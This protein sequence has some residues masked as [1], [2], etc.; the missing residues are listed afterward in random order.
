MSKKL[1]R[2][3]KLVSRKFIYYL[4]PSMLMIFA[5]QFSSLLDGILIGN[6]ISGEALAATSLVMPVLY[7]IQAPGFALGVGGS[8]VVANKLGK[9]DIEGAK[10]AFSIAI[11]ISVGLSLIFAGVS[12]FVSSPL[13]KLF[14]EASYEY[15][16]PYIYMYLLTDPIL[17]IA[18]LLGSFMAVDN[19]PK[20]SSIFFIIANVA[21]VGFEFLFIKTFP[22]PM[23]GAALSTG[24]GFFVALAV[25]PF[26]LK[27]KKR[28]LKFSF[29]VKNAGIFSI[30]K[31]SST[32]GV[33][34]VLTATQMLIV[35]IFLGKLIT[36]PVDLLAF[37]LISNVVFVFDLFCGGILNVIPNICGIFYGEK[38]YYS[39]RS[40]TRKIYWINFIV[41]C[42]ITAFIAIA[43]QV[44]SYIFGYTD[45][46]NMDY[47]GLLIR[48]YLIS[49]L[50]YE[51]NKFNMNYYPSVDKTIPSLVTV[52][53]REAIIVLPLTLVLLHTNGIM[54]YCIACAVTEVATVLITYGFVLIYNK[55]KN[56]RGIFMFERGDVESFDV[57]LDNN[58]DNASQVSEQ[59]TSFAKEHGIQERESQIVGLAAEEIVANIITYGYRHNHKNYIDVSLKKTDKALILRIRDDGMP[60]DPTKYE[61][62]N[63]D[64]YSTSG[65]QLISKLTDKMTYMRVL[66]LNNTIFEINIGGQH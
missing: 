46:S 53:L 49:F 35:N 41:T 23:Y 42:A 34:M 47:V 52:F 51:I 56:T 62:D 66:N 60:F 40:V 17:T 44:Y 18:L 25:V 30:V 19:N 4:I 21:K 55:R 32:S 61:F 26:Y 50:P 12:F 33:N 64:N 8:I 27:S 39:L 6:L 3:D 43:P 38:D 7:V 31:S 15:S 58:E 45:Q 10:K 59:L 24:A 22:D 57:S 63:D 11:I 36:D 1:E 16:Y 37:G 54:G 14:G 5:M 48:V 29:N 28:M 13:A 65:I 2:N 9:R 20:L